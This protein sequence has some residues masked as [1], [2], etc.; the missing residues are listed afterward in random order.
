MKRLS[1]HCRRDRIQQAQAIYTRGPMLEIG[2]FRRQADA[3]MNDGRVSVALDLISLCSELNEAYRRSSRMSLSE[4]D[5]ARLQAAAAGA[6][7]EVSP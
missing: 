5:R 4:V 7:P 3:M 2:A 6:V 1:E